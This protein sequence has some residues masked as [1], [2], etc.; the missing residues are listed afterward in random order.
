[1]SINLKLFKLAVG[2]PVPAPRRVD[3]RMK[4]TERL[5]Y[6]HRLDMQGYDRAP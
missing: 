4:L 1:M 3:E 5:D 6:P 2:R